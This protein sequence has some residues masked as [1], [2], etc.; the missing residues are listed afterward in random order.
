MSSLYY[1]ICQIKYETLFLSIHAKR[2]FHITLNDIDSLWG[3][4]HSTI[5]NLY[6]GNVT[7]EM[8]IHSSTTAQDKNTGISL[9]IE[10]RAI[11]TSFFVFLIFSGG[12]FCV[13]CLRF[14][15]AVEHCG[16]M[17]LAFEMCV[18]SQRIQVLASRV[19]ANC[20]QVKDKLGVRP[21]WC[22]IR[23]TDFSCDYD[24]AG[25]PRRFNPKHSF[26]LAE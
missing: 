1:N 22:V 4:V 12:V 20:N 2:K 3:D 24:L 10:S 25:F 13:L 26:L 15:L 11:R 23:V 14:T 19:G 8:N 18:R 21:R 6:F 7:D 9:K 16:T 5:Q 17:D